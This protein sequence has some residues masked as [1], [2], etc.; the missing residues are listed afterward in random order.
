[1][2]I[3]EALINRVGRIVVDSFRELELVHD[4]CLKLALLRIL[5][6]ITPD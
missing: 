5:L 2:E 4:L 1:M 3:E 6:R